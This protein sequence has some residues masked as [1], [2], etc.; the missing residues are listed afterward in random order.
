MCSEMNSLVAI[1]S[2][3]E[4]VVQEEQYLDFTGRELG[5]DSI[6]HAAQPASLTNA[7]EQPPRDRPR[8]GCLAA[9]DASEKRCDSLR[10]L[11][12]Q[13]VPG[14]PCSDRL[15]QIL[16]RPGRGQHHDLAFG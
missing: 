8:Q 9:C 1:S 6:G 3:L 4:M 11:A 10:R 13:Q 12:L 16:L 5:G 14:G 15:E 2:V 7:V